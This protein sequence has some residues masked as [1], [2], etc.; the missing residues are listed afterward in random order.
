MLFNATD[1]LKDGAVAVEGDRITDVGG[2]AH[3]RSLYPEAE[4]IGGRRRLLMPGLIDA[5]T[6]GRG[7]SFVQ[8]GSGFDFLENCLMEWPS[9]L[10]LPPELNAPLCAWR[11]LRKGCT[12]L[13]HNEMC[14]ALDETALDRAK[15]TLA[16]YGKAGIRAAYSPG[17]RDENALAYGDEEFLKALP[18][19]LHAFAEPLVRFDKAAARELFFAQFDALHRDCN[20]DRTRVFLG[21]NW[22]HG[23]SDAYLLAVKEKAD[24]LGGLPIHIHTL[25]TPHQRGYGMKKYGMSLLKRLDGL[26][27]VN[28]WLTLGHAVYL[29]E[30]DVALLAVRKGSITH[31][32]SCNFA[33]RNGVAPV[34][35][36]LQAGVNVAIGLDEKG[37]NDDEDVFMELRM[38][39]YLHR[40]QGYDLMRDAALRPGE[41]LAM[42][43]ANAARSLGME[44]L[45]GA[46]VP[47]MKADVIQL[48]LT[49]IMD[50]PCVQQ[51]ADLLTLLIHR[52]KG[53]QVRF[54]MVDGKP[55]MQDGE[56]LTLDVEALYEEVRAY[57]AAGMTDAQKAYAA[58]MRQLKPYMQQHIAGLERFERSPYYMVNTKM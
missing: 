1:V 29:D 32:P 18:G 58:H 15:V 12:T 10:D 6:H 56:C 14:R 43:L 57:M 25:Q 49:E 22:A 2:S 30:E 46:L 39:Y 27:L 28:R 3:I 51:D 16:G 33:M 34:Y 13:H 37:I 26:G 40:L 19:D 48:D 38:A 50:D 54:V 35:A 21:P 8:R 24:A 20:S 41:V 53:T 45:T 17:I 36:M 52:A 4:R 11:H 42:G 9:T 44:A 55:V 5:H 7:M 47:G 23:A 31:H